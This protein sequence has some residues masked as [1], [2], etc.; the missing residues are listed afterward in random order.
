MTSFLR[1]VKFLRA[2]ASELCQEAHRTVAM[3][4]TLQLAW[5]GKVW[6]PLAIL[7]EPRASQHLG[8]MRIDLWSTCIAYLFQKTEVVPDSVLGPVKKQVQAPTL[9][10]SCRIASEND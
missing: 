4:H 3:L 5:C 10:V 6:T 7:P 9:T 1:P 2:V 8:D